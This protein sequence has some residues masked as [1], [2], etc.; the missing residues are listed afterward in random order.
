MIDSNHARY[1]KRASRGN[2][3]PKM[4]FENVN[5]PRTVYYSGEFRISSRKRIRKTKSHIN[6]RAHTHVSHKNY[7]N[8]NRYNNAVR[9][10]I[11]NSLLSIEFLSDNTD[12]AGSCSIRIILYSINE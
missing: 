8:L 10:E 3:F 9:I 5:K 12:S 7:C 2:A 11:K 1:E 4:K 6:A